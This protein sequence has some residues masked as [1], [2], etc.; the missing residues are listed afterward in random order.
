[1]NLLIAL[2]IGTN[3][4]RAHKFRSILSMLGIVL[5]V[6][7]LIATLAL[8][9]GIERGTRAF[10]QQVGG[11]E[12]VN[13]VNKE[14][15]NDMIDFWNL[16][17]GRTLR[18]A[19][20]I[21]SSAPLVSHVSPE[22]GFG[23]AIS[24]ESGR[25]DRKQVRGVFPDHFTVARH[26]LLAGR[27]L[28]DT[29]IEQSAKAAV[30]GDSIAEQLWPGL[31]KEQV[32]NKI[33][34]I[35]GTP[36]RVV[37]VLPLYERDE[38]RFR[39]S[40]GKKLSV[41]RWDPFR[42]KNESVLIPFSTMFYEFRS[43]AFPMDSIDSIRLESLVLR[44]G[45]LDQFQA[46]LDQVRSALSITHRGVDDFD[47]ETREEWFDRMESSIRATRLSGGLI[48]TI[49]LVVGGIGIMNIMLASISERVREIGI[50][51][52]V[53]ARSSDIFVQILIESV[54][55]AF[56]GGLLGI[57]ASVGLIEVLKAIAPSENT[58][59]MTPGA[60]LF[61]VGFAVLAGLVSG[62]YPALRASRLNPITALRYE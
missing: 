26:E 14:I 22:L 42:Q 44:I 8:T 28:T 35:N 57:V 30:I 2:Q 29:D 17:P 39:R 9:T 19:Q 21:R 40:Q 45:D 24:D 60:I 36:F 41:R 58:P 32:I 52:A 56:I 18:D 10:M 20:I 3:E 43:G 7:S 54:T 1:M 27:W 49:S 61:S 50:R 34:Q 55:I 4:I 31:P 53:G 62:L 25:S 59:V 46:A 5:G 51:L 11:L 23:A 33:L 15:S 47:L 13:V 16:S 12:Y 6:S 48:A 37:G 38:D